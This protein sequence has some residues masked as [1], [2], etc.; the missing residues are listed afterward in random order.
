M[1]LYIYRY[2]TIILYVSICIHI[3]KYL[4]FGGISKVYIFVIEGF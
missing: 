3:C 2:T 4:F 1:Y